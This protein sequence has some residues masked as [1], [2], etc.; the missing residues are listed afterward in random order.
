LLASTT[1]LAAQ[2]PEPAFDETIS[3]DTLVVSSGFD[4]KTAFDLAQGTSLLAGS[5]LRRRVQGTLGETL[6]ATAG[7][8]ATAYGPGASRPIIRGLGGDRI[9]IL[10]NGVGSLDASGI[11]PDHSS[12]LEPLFASQIEVLRGPA[13]LLYGSSAIGGAVNVVDNRIPEQRAPKPLSGAI[14][15]RRFGPADESTGVASLLAGSGNLAVQV[16]A[17]RRDTRDVDIPGVARIDADAPADQPDGTL[18]NSDTDTSSAARGA[19]GVA[20]RGHF[21]AAVSTYE[22]NYGVPVDEPVSIAM[23]RRR[24]DLHGELTEPF[25]IFRGAKAQFGLGD[26]SHREILEHTIVNT[27][28]DNQAWEGRLELPH[29]FSEAVSG[30]WGVQATRSDF[31]AVGEEV[32]TPPYVTNTGALFALEEWKRGPL[33]LQLGGRVETQSITLGDVP[34][35][36][37][38]V[39]GYAARSGEK[40]RDTGVSGSAGVVYYPVKDWSAA[41]SLAYSERLPTAQ[42]RFSNGPHGGTGAWEVGRADLDTEKSLGLELSLRKRAGFVTGSVGAFVNRF[43]GHIF[44]QQLPD[45]A[46]PE[47]RNEEGLTPYQFTAKDAEFYGAEAELALHL[48]DRPEHSLHLSLMSDYVHAQQTTDDEPLPRTPPL[49]FGA[50]LRFDSARWHA[51]VEVRTVARQ[52]RVAASETRTDGYTLLNADIRYALPLGGVSC[53]LFA[54]GVNL[55]NED[56]R[57]HASF[58]KD[59]A[60]L[61]GRGVLLGLRAAF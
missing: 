40:H 1:L 57:V 2:A 56:A 48:V 39:P 22:T 18:P 3:L 58:L 53:E 29:A 38:P 15:V 10:E 34:D 5:E 31:S 33:S 46:I 17:L 8:N 23:R 24:L 7:V 47:D 35:D 32:A 61:P 30:T 50:A 55:T 12:T 41:L 26:Y 60:P 54:R 45:D 36:L 20:A 37:P 28:F 49:R 51:G 6:S 44:E 59:F 21:G 16:N 19:T 25:G 4:H 11:S 42:E 9:R 52:N 14:E 43:D 27:T 13:T